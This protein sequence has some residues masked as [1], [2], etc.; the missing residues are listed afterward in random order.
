MQSRTIKQMAGG[1]KRSLKAI[2]KK[3]LEM[4]ADWGDVDEYNVNLLSELAN[5]CGKAA[6]SLY[7]AADCE[8]D[9][10]SE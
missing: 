4:S 5:E 2:Q 8:T 3:L 10:E 7:D 9:N 6:T 1:Q